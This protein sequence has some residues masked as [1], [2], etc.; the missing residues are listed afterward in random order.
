MLL[1]SCTAG[2]MQVKDYHAEERCLEVRTTTS[3][4]FPSN[5]LFVSKFRLSRIV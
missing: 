4:Q 2:L 3:E 1:K 5:Y